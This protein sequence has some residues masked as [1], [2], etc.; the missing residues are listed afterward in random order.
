MKCSPELLIPNTSQVAVAA[1]TFHLERPNIFAIGF[2]DGTISIYNASSMFHADGKHQ[3]ISEVA[4]VKKVHGIVTKA[5]SS[6][7]E[8]GNALC[9]FDPTTTVTDVGDRGTSIV[10]ICFVPGSEITI[11]SVGADGKCCVVDFTLKPSSV[12]TWYC[13]ATCTCLSIIRVSP[14]VWTAQYDG[15]RSRPPSKVYTAYEVLVAIGRQDGRVLLYELDGGLLAERS[16]EDSAPVIDVEWLSDHVTSDGITNPPWEPL[17]SDFAD[18]G[19]RTRAKTEPILKP[20]QRV[21]RRA[22]ADAYALADSVDAKAATYNDEARGILDNPSTLQVES[23]KDVQSAIG[24]HY[25][26]QTDQ[27]INSEIKDF[28]P[29]QSPRHSLPPQIPPRPKPRKDGKSAMRN[30]GKLH[31]ISRVAPENGKMTQLGMK[32]VEPSKEEKSK[33]AKA[34]PGYGTASYT[35][36]SVIHDFAEGQPAISLSEQTMKPNSTSSSSGEQRPLRRMSLIPSRGGSKDKTSASQGMSK[37]TPTEDSDDTIVSWTAGSARRHIVRPNPSDLLRKP[38]ATHSITLGRQED[39]GS[40]SVASDDTIIDW[41]LLPQTQRPFDI[42]EDSASAT[43]TPVPAYRCRISASRKL[44]TASP[45]LGH[46]SLNAIPKNT[47]TGKAAASSKITTRRS[48]KQNL[49]HADVAA[50]NASFE[51]RIALLEKRVMA[52]SEAQTEKLV[53]GMAKGFE[54]QKVWI[55]E[56]L[57]G[58]NGKEEIGGRK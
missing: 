14:G 22:I 35:E 47:S 32:I 7:N 45:A 8:K 38:R 56:M 11:I 5:S 25:L 23:E 53:K 41:N 27:A 24:Q 34:I 13:G 19:F 57:R 36:S 44:S 48:S 54:E 4:T 39:T 49:G 12:R 6:S 21:L 15:S 55:R 17:N 50:L 20:P 33:N 9:E 52:Q 30:A 1:A 51:E 2:A 18:P 43:E 31:S 29:M 10:S 46:G 26:T 3:R 42:H 37:S 28:Q 40:H 58:R 16:F